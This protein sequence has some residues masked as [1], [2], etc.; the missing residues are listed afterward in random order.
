MLLI[1]ENTS[2]GGEDFGNK[3]EHMNIRIQLTV[4]PKT[5]YA[6][7][8]EEKKNSTMDTICNVLLTKF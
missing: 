1:F 2:V 6:L 3:D 4:F 5:V 7:Q 8:L